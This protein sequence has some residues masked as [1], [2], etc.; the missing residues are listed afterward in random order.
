MTYSPGQAYRLRTYLRKAPSWFILGGPADADE[1]QVVHRVWPTC[2]I[3]ACEPNP[4][5]L[6]YQKGNDFPASGILLPYALSDRCGK[7]DI[8]IGLTARQTSMFRDVK[9]R[10]G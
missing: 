10:R 3:V 8:I 1:A 5:M 9:R 6:Q 4:E 7:A 2:K